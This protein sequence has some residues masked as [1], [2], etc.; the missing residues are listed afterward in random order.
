MNDGGWAAGQSGAVWGSGHLAG[1]KVQL[2]GVHLADLRVGVADGAPVV[3]V[4]VRDA[5]GALRDLLDA[6]QLELRLVA[7]D[8]V[9]REAATD[10]R[11]HRRRP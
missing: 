9:H 4:H 7:G 5:L 6:A 10:L 2:D 3:G 1:L 8:A 11:H